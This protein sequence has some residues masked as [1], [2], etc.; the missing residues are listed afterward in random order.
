MKKMLKI[1]IIPVYG[2]EVTPTMYLM[3]D[4]IV[5]VFE[6]GGITHISTIDGHTEKTKTSVDEIVALIEKS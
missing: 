1:D 3:T 4:K 2:S 5:A 6:K